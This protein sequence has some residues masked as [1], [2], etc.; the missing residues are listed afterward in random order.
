MAEPPSRKPAGNPDWGE[1]R[2]ICG[3]SH[4]I[5]DRIQRDRSQP[6]PPWDGIASRWVSQLCRRA[7]EPHG[8]PEESGKQISDLCPGGLWSFPPRGK[9]FAPL[10]PPWLIS[11]AEPTSSV[12]R[13]WID[14]I[15]RQVSRQQ[16]ASLT[17][18]DF[19][20]LSTGETAPSPEG[21]GLA[22]G[23]P[24]KA[25]PLGKLSAKR[26]EEGKREQKSIRGLSRN[27]PPQKF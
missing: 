4:P 17:P 3:R 7:T 6:E 20:E 2:R 9:D 16:V 24:Q 18:F 25:S 8:T 10:K 11:A 26:T 21:E 1:R 27:R 15:F 14:A 19:V 12:C 5:E 13:D 23:S 22:C